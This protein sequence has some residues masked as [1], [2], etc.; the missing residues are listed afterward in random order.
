MSAQVIFRTQGVATSFVNT[1]NRIPI[2]LTSGI[3][4]RFLNTFQPTPFFQTG[5]VSSS[6]LTTNVTFPVFLTPSE[7]VAFFTTA[8]K[9]TTK[10]LV[11]TIGTMEVA[12]GYTYINVPDATGDY[13]ATTNPG[14]YNILPLPFNAARPYRENVAL[15]TVYRIWNVYGSNT[16]SPDA[17]NQQYDN[18]YEYQ[19]FIPTQT[20]AAQEQEIIR[21][22]YEIILIAAPYFN[23]TDTGGT[24]LD[25]TAGITYHIITGTDTNFADVLADNDYVYYVDISNGNLV[26]I[27]QV[28]KAF[29]NTTL[30]LNGSPDLPSEGA[31]LFGNTTQI[32]TAVNS[33]GTVDT[34]TS[35]PYTPVIG[36]G[37]D[38]TTN[39]ASGEFLYYVETATGD[40]KLMGNILKNVNPLTLNLIDVTENVATAGEGLF[41]SSSALDV[42]NSQG[43][44]DY[45]AGN[46]IFGDASC[47]FTLFSVG[48]SLYYQDGTTGLLEIIGTIDSIISDTELTISAIP[49]NPPT[50]GE[51]LFASDDNA[52]SL[53]S[54][55]GT[56]ASYGSPSTYYTL[57]GTDTTFTLFSNSDYVYIVGSDG[58]YNELG[59]IAFIQSNESMVFYSV[60]D[61]TV[62]QGNF[63]IASP[64]QISLINIEGTYLSYETG[65][66]TN[67]EGDLTTFLTT[68]EPQQYLFYEDANGQFIKTGQIFQVFDDTNVWLYDAPEGSP[69]N[70]TQ[71]FTSYSLNTETASYANY[72]GNFDLYEIA[73]QFPGWFVGST[74]IV[75]DEL[76]INCLSRLRYEFLQGVMCGRCDEGYLHTYSLYVGMLSAMEVQEWQLAV[77]FYNK[78]KVICAEQDGSSCGC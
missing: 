67:L 17:Q 75:V 48:Q 77:D 58:V 5:G 4:T 11:P 64:V 8:D 1:T 70:T 62:T 66:Y 30:A 14:G 72:R 65:A 71:L 20:N 54:S 69:D 7:A 74:G 55:G 27:E 22:V 33:G 15:W 68:A 56:F 73:N 40:Y 47:Q 51:R 32:T 76:L 44:F 6:F 2:F 53:N 21:G 43:V 19:L 61:I 18:P 50:N 34:F 12:S 16:Q 10:L 41:S 13:D 29:N 38:F 23:E 45:Q 28:L 24:Y 49:I 36:T 37:T 26:E 39:F 25:D 78:L 42:I 59:Q 57:T 35:A 46:S 31:K 60:N 52:I 3:A 63:I 9:G